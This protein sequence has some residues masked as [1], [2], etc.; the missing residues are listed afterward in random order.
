[1]SLIDDKYNWLLANGL[2]LGQPVF[3]EQQSVDSIG[4]FRVYEFG[5][6][7]FHPEI[8]AFEVHGAILFKYQEIGAEQSFLGYP[9]S[10][11]LD[12]PDGTGKYSQFHFGMIFWKPTGELTAVSSGDPV[13][14][15]AQFPIPAAWSTPARDLTRKEAR[16]I[17]VFLIGQGAFKLRSVTPLQFD[18]N[19]KVLFPRPETRIAI[20]P[21]VIAGIQFTNDVNP[22]ANI[23]DNLDAR[24]VVGLYRLASR[25]AGA[26]GVNQIRHKGIG[27][28]VGG[29]D[30]CHNTGRALDL[31]GISG[32]VPIPLTIPGVFGQY[33]LDVLADW[34]N[35]TVPVSG[36]ATSHTWPVTFTATTFRLSPIMQP[37]GSFLF[38]TIYDFAVT[39]FADTSESPHGNTLPPTQLGS[40]S[41][42]V[43]HPD[44][45]DP[46]LRSR[47]QDH[48]HMQVGPTFLEINP[49]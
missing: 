21:A 1:M 5:V 49:P 6:I 34:G 9:V 3:A 25:L 41:R 15:L 43:I 7:Y 44:H 37:L 45:G 17:V 8:G 39:E 32:N 35:Q 2:N 38:Q 29:A 40:Q 4:S 30:D 26:F 20:E 36:G 48:M 11:E 31:S 28:G 16:D 23:L 13:G 18:N 14:C 19:C 24:M 42:F 46:T 22:A 27:H 47:H 33:T 12:L 10:D